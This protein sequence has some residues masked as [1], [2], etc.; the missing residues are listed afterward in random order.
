MFYSL[1][2]LASD[3]IPYFSFTADANHL[4]LPSADTK[5][6]NQAIAVKHRRSVFLGT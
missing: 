6:S 1:T 4:T 3:W 5:G 2:L